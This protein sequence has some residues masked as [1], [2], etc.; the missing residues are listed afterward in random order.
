VGL[1]SEEN[2]SPPLRAKIS[3]RAQDK[4]DEDDGKMDKSDTMP[5]GSTNLGL[6]GEGWNAQFC[7]DR[8]P[9]AGG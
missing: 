4:T 1:H 2:P 7:S 8:W 5:L 6:A 9:A 3:D